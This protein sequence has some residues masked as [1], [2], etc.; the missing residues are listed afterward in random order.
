MTDEHQSEK[1]KIASV[2]IT[3]RTRKD[4]GNIASLAESICSVGLMQPI[5]INEKNELIDGQRRI[6]AFL[7]LGIK[8]IPFYQVNLEQI[9][10]G[11]FHANSK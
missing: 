3:N 1:I 5:V 7:Q 9:F 2:I 10:L 8:E 11:E 4:L 6:K